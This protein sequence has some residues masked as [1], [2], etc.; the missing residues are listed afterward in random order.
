[1]FDLN[2][3]RNSFLH[4]WFFAAGAPPSSNECALACI[5]ISFVLHLSVHRSTMKMMHRKGESPGIAGFVSN[6]LFGAGSNDENDSGNNVEGEGGK[7]DICFTIHTM[8]P[9]L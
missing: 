9:M 1:M 2:G 4:F 6:L 5:V 7:N 3:F 8:V